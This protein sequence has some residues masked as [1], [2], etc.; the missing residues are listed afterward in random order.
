MDRIG[1]LSRHG[2]RPS[3]STATAT[4]A[5]PSGSA[6]HDDPVDSEARPDWLKLK[7]PES[8]AVKREAEED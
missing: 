1:I 6:A 8:P 4:A 2:F 5:A 7:N 3:A